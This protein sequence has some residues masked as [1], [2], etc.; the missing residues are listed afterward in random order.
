MAAERRFNGDADGALIDLAEADVAY[1][2][3]A[4]IARSDPS[5]HEGRVRFVDADPGHPQPAR[6]G[7]GGTVRPGGCRL[8]PLPEHRHPAGSI[9]HEKLSHLYWRWADIVN[10]RGGIAQPFL[11]QAIS[12]A[13]RAIE[14]DPESVPAYFTKG[15]ALHGVGSQG[16]GARGQTHGRPSSRPSRASKARSPST[17]PSSWPTTTSATPGSARRA[18][19]WTPASTRARRWNMPWR[20]FNGPS[21]STPTTPT[22]TTTRASRS[23]AVAVSNRG[24]APTP[25]PR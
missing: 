16:D 18:M 5:I 15:G 12:S 1:A 9:V 2:L 10:D 19:R 4:D 7:G 6:R 13:D 17:R 25:A 22:P 8:R 11:E 3:A 23:G 14:L 24:P 20:R 21:R